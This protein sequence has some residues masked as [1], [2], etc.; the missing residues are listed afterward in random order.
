[1]EAVQLASAVLDS[2]PPAL[3]QPGTLPGLDFAAGVKVT[4]LVAYFAGGY[5]LTVMQSVDGID[6]P[7]TV[8]VPQCAEQKVLEGVTAAVKAGHLWATNGPM[9]FCGDEPAAGAIAKSAVLRLPPL[10]IALTAMTPEELPDGWS[11]GIASALSLQTAISAKVAPPGTILPWTTVCKAINDSLNSRFLELVPNGP[12]SWPCEAHSA[13]AV[14]FRLPTTATAGAGSGGSDASVSPGFGEKPQASVEPAIA[15]A[16]LDGAALVALADAMADVQAAVAAYG[17]P[18]I[19]KVSVEAK[20]LPPEARKA[21]RAELTKA[22]G[23]F[24]ELD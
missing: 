9:S 13:A 3:L 2:L 16:S 21:L 6:Y 11:G 22:V 12:V 19:F 1:L 4:D 8:A 24:A 20:G 15:R 10:P 18:L 7:E 5:T 17:T 14:Q 23:G